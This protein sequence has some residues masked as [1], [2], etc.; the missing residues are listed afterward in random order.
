METPSKDAIQDTCLKKLFG[1]KRATAAVSMGVGKTRIGLRHMRNMYEFGARKFLVAAPK[2][3]VFKSWNDE[4]DLLGWGFL[5]EHTEFVTYRSLHKMENVYDVLYLD[6]CHSLKYSHVPFLNSFTGRI[7]GLTGTPPEKEGSEKHKMVSTFCPVVFSY[8]TE[9][10]VSENILNDYRIILHR[11]PLSSVKDIRIEFSNGGSILTS[12]SE[13]Y[14]YWTKRMADTWAIGNRGEY[15]KLSI[16]RMTGMKKYLSKEA[17]VK[18]LIPDFEEKCIVFCN[19]Q[20]QAD[21]IS[22]YSYHSENPDSEYNLE[23]FKKGEI[24]VLTSVNQLNEGINI[25]DLKYGII[26]H[27]YGNERQASQRIGRLLRLNPKETA[28]IHI[29][30]YSDTVDE[31]WVFNAL[32][33]FNPDKISYA[34]A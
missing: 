2:K 4:L 21:R 9:E 20:E 18:T 34:D 19:T 16:N 27:A 5:K 28:Y 30:M 33:N 26:M 14:E 32:K 25:P 6:E 23:M 11:V 10:A 29:L 7:I 31:T 1:Y 8:I 17:Y 24:S 22:A 12:E 3:S 15:Q 13:H